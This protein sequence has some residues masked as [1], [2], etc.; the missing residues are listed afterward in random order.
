[1]FTLTQPTCYLFPFCSPI[2]FPVT[3]Q[4]VPVPITLACMQVLARPK[5]GTP[6]VPYLSCLLP[7]QLTMHAGTSVHC[8]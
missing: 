5:P 1:M 7:E 2:G 4:G 6:I 8:A 3:E